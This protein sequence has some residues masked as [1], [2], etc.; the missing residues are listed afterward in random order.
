MGLGAHRM[1]G[2]NGF[3]GPTG[4]G[5][6]LVEQVGALG[7]T[8]EPGQQQREVG[9]VRGA[10]E[11]A[12]R[13]V[14]RPPAGGDPL[15]GEPGALVVPHD[16][17]RFGEE[18][19]PQIGQERGGVGHDAAR[20][21]E[22]GAQQ[23]DPL[24]AQGRFVL[25][26]GGQAQHG[27]EGGPVVRAQG[28][29]RRG[30]FHGPPQR[31]DRL[32][33]RLHVPGRIRRVAQDMTEVAVPAGLFVRVARGAGHGGAPGGDRVVER[34]PPGA[35]LEAVE[36]HETEV[37]QADALLGAAGGDRSGGMTQQGLGPAQGLGIAALL[38]DR[39]HPHARVV[40]RAGRGGG[41]VRFARQRGVERAQSGRHLV[42]VL[43]ADRGEPEQ[44][45]GER[46]P[47]GPAGRDVAE[48]VGVAER[49]D[50]QAPEV[51][52]GRGDAR[53]HVVGRPSRLRPGEPGHGPGV[54][55]RPLDLPKDAVRRVLGRSHLCHRA[56][57]RVGSP[58]PRRDPD[59]VRLRRTPMAGSPY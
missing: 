24:G 8:G 10:L 16:L 12:G 33:E 29:V 39:H 9:K 2:G 7:M 44:G 38:E 51:S 57:V 6:R 58:Q 52:A 55:V 37:R 41:A 59:P 3:E 13:G 19:D 4:D 1:A 48:E 50:S 20:L 40:R 46:G 53:A 22:R 54:A 35:V 56:P 27:T 43:L 25:P 42:R 36:E 32:A 18:G 31:G 17:G 26:V 5:D 49:Q 47:V 23:R 11:G 34:L 30:E 15:L 21:R 28:G 45:G 14:R